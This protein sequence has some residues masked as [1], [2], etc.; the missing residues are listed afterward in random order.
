MRI[1][2]SMLAR[3][4]IDQV[5]QGR[6]RLARIQEQATTGLRINRPSDDPVDY[7]ASRRLKGALGETDQF[8]RGID[9]SRT[10]IATTENA[11][12]DALGVLDEARARAV[13]AANDTNDG[14]QATLR[15]QVEGLFASLFDL[16]NARSPEG[17]YVFAG[18][19]SD[20]PAFSQT[21]SFVSGGAAPVVSFDG[22]GSQ[23]RVELEEGV[24]A[25][26][27]LAGDR[28]FQGGVD[29]FQALTNLWT[30]IDTDDDNLIRQAIGELDAAHEQLQNELVRIG[31]A[32][33][34]ADRAEDRL[35]LRQEELTARVSRL[36][37]AD[38][39]QVYSDLAAQEVALQASLQV[40]SRLLGP[41]LLEFL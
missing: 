26:V 11:V 17:A 1:T 7:Q 22:D 37:D 13:Q 9:L 23:V 32:G 3:L 19:T 6:T 25:D 30:G 33:A 29:A 15:T 16:G 18:L 24:Y 38:A 5:N 39:Y 31:Q 36:E 2:N 20:V 12:L 8:L 41:S 35:R 27:T 14:E 4:G 28:V 40:A 21:G 10:R 34:A